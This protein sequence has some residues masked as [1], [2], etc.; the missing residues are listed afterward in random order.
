M[1]HY[2]EMTFHG[3]MLLARSQTPKL[4]N[5]FPSGEVSGHQPTC[6]PNNI[7]CRS[8][9]Q[10]RVH[11]CSDGLYRRRPTP[12]E[13]QE[14]KKKNV[15]DRSTLTTGYSLRVHSSRRWIP[16]KIWMPTNQIRAILTRAHVRIPPITCACTS[17]ISGYIKGVE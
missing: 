2:Q 7:T 1:N 11:Q 14:K 6:L 5:S 8:Q 17:G 9:I 16:G 12:L 15:R 10:Q 4:Q 3:N 13:T